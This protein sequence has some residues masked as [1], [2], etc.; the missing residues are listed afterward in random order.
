VALTRYHVLRRLPD[1]D[2]HG[3]CCRCWGLLIQV[4]LHQITDVECRQCRTYY[5]HRFQ[6]ELAM[7]NYINYP[8]VLQ[9]HT[10][11]GAPE[12]MAAPTNQSYFDLFV[13]QNP[14]ISVD[15]KKKLKTNYEMI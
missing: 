9:D 7:S 3:K 8:L 5:L 14:H 13:A 6:G 12:S 10:H 2:G 4:Q 15:K 11:I 1:E